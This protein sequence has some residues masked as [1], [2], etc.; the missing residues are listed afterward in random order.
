LYRAAYKESAL[1]DFINAWME[2]ARFGADSHR[3]IT[4]R[5]MKLASG[6]PQAAAEAERMI[7]EKVA[8]F[9]EAQGA[10]LSALVTGKGFDIAAVKAYAPYR[11]AVRANR[12]RLGA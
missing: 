5:M 3:V 12:R 7:S 9:G 1:F 2:A 4:L 10:L 8:A 11:R 6:G